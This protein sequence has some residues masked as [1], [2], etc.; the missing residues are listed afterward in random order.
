MEAMRKSANSS[1]GDALQAALLSLDLNGLSS[2][3]VTTALTAEVDRVLGDT[4]LGSVV[5]EFPTYGRVQP[6]SGATPRVGHLDFAIV[7]A[8]RV[9][10]A[11]EIDRSD[12]KFSLTKLCHFQ[13]RGAACIWIRWGTDPKVRVPDGVELIYVPLGREASGPKRR[14]RVSGP[15]QS[16]MSYDCPVSPCGSPLARLA[17]R[18]LTTRPRTRLGS[19][20]AH[21]VW[22]R[23]VGR[24]GLSTSTETSLSNAKPRTSSRH[25]G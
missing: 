8:E 17:P 12:K 2:R 9:V 11:V 6:P 24:S 22:H 25:H 7:E 16:D 23:M 3:Q 1:V 15:R 18:Q 5:R 20:F 14:T 19:P 21:V 13:D 10:L 4:G